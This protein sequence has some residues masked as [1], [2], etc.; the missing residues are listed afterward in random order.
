VRLKLLLKRGTQVKAYSD[1]GP[2]AAARI[3]GI[4]Y[5][6]VIVTSPLAMY[7]RGSMAGQGDAAVFAV[8]LLGHETLYRLGA[9]A[10]IVSAACYIVVTAL[11]YRLFRPVNRS[12]ALIATFFSLIGIAAGTVGGLF[13]VAPL[14]ILH[15]A[16]H[17][18]AFSTQQLDQ[19]AMLSVN[20]GGQAVNIGIVFFGFYCL[21]I[22][23]LI[24]KSTFLP[25]ILGTGMMLAGLGWLS[26][27]YPPLATAL[28]PFNLMTGGLGEGALTVWLLAVGLNAQRWND[29]ANVEDRV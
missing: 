25:S 29:Q 1:M 11:F 2:K 13:N 19:L 4:F 18:G 8:N 14:T 9:A 28:M 16:P 3:A 24:V 23:W 20:L 26:F 22:G 10:D 17:L 5:L 7:I 21:L 15:N 27:I 12:L 6:L